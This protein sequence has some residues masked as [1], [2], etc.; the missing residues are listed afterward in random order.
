MSA[1]DGRLRQIVHVVWW[2][3][4]GATFCVA[5][6]FAARDPAIRRAVIEH[7]GMAVVGAAD[8][9]AGGIGGS[10]NSD[11]EAISRASAHRQELQERAAERDGLARAATR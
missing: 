11:I 8:A 6:P 2:D 10:S 1:R 4:A 5:G 3:V 9:V 7:A